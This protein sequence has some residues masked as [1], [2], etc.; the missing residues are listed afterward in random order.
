LCKEPFGRC[1]HIQEDFP[2]R[3]SY[4]DVLKSEEQCQSKLMISLEITLEENRTVKTWQIFAVAF[5]R[6]DAFQRFT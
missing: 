5:K 1:K 2:Q 3:V 4:R 6:V